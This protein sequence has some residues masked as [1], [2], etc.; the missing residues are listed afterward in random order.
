MVSA[1]VSDDSEAAI[2]EQALALPN[3]EI[4]TRVVQQ[5]KLPIHKQDPRISALAVKTKAAPAKQVA[6]KRI[7]VRKGDTL[8]AIFSRNKIS[9]RDVYDIIA[10]GKV[11]KGLRNLRPGQHIRLSFAEQG[12]FTGLV[13][14]ITKFKSLQVNRSAKGYSAKQV[15]RKPNIRVAYVN[16][17]IRDS[18]FL[19]AKKAGLEQSLIMELAGIFGWDIDFALDIRR[20]DSF[21]VVYEE[22]YLD[23]EKI[24]H[25]NILAA[26]FVNRGRSYRAVRYAAKDN[27]AD[28][29]TPAGKNMRK[30]FLRSPVDFRRISSRFG[31][32]HHPVLNRTRLHKG[33]DYAA[34]RGTPVRATGDGKIIHRARKGG[35]GKTI[36]IRHGGKYSTLYAHLSSY[37]RKARGKVKQGQ[38]IGY[39]GTT[40]RSTGPHLHY[41]FRLNGAHRNPL[42]VKL[43]SATSINKRYKKDFLNQTRGLIAQLDGLRRIEIALAP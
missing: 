25:G 33:V 16:G 15:V 40:G 41:E 29:Y 31:R 34:K 3:T 14:E 23:G 7:K 11:T 35:Y 28:Y 27:R 42:T 20:G 4:S 10:L 1:L 8:A 24:R 12:K 32:R 13:H 37:D 9:A 2:S 18:L 17:K 21:H 39:V 43:P 30:A 26:E 19:D 36:I 6:Q 38:V 5:L 22:Q